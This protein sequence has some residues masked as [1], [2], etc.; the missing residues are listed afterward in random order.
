MNPTVAPGESAVPREAVGMA[1]YGGPP[2]RPRA[3]HGVVDPGSGIPRAMHWHAER[4]IDR[5][6][7]GDLARPSAATNAGKGGGREGKYGVLFSDLRRRDWHKWLPYRDM[8]NRE[9]DHVLPIGSGKYRR[10]S[11]DLA[12]LHCREWVYERI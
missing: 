11:V 10:R 6:G 2:H 12:C 5:R 8:R 3:L 7:R 9:E 1:R 4:E